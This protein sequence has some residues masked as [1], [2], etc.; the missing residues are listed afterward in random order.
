MNMRYKQLP[1]SGAAQFDK[2]ISDVPEIKMLLVIAL[3]IPVSLE[4]SQF[5]IISVQIHCKHN[6]YFVSCVNMYVAVLNEPINT[7]NQKPFQT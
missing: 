1:F 2:Y 5:N 4:S 3:H 7:L 6:L